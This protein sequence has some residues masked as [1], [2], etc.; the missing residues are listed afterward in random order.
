[1]NITSG[2][3][4]LAAEEHGSGTPVVLLVHAGVTDQ[5]SWAAVIDALPDHR[6]LTY[7]ARGYGRTTYEPEDGWSPVGDAVA[8]LDAYDVSSAIVVG[9]SMGGRTALDLALTHPDRVSALVLIGSAVSGAPD[10]EHLEPGLEDLET[11][12]DAAYEAD[13]HATLNDLEAVLWLDGPF[14]PG[15]VTGETRDL[16][17][18]MNRIALDAPDP[19]ERGDDLDAWQEAATVGVPTLVM[20]GEY[21]LDHT[22]GSAVHLAAT[23]PGARLVE[24]PGVAHLP[25]LE[26]DPLT[27][28]EI[29]GFVAAI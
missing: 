27:L 16:F 12:Y 18:D 5:R 1:M 23:V 29:A 13:D 28:R 22:Q 14:H 9:C 10:L 4:V 20:I 25:H 17:L 2:S 15:R 19:G 3:A 24:L 26:R 6:C 7:D 21:D 11:R 8:V